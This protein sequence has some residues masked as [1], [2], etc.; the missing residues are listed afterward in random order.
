[1]KRLLFILFGIIAIANSAYA[2]DIIVLYDTTEIEA[3][4]VDVGQTTITYK[5]WSEQNGT[6]LTIERSKI[7]Y[8]KRQDGTKD[9]LMSTPSVTAISGSKS[10]SSPIV[11]K[12]KP[13]QFQGYTHGGLICLYSNEYGL[14]VG[15]IWDVSLGVNLFERFYIGGTLGIY[16]IFASKYIDA[17]TKIKSRELLIPIAPISFKYY[18]T[19]GNVL[20]PFIDFSAGAF[21]LS[22][23]VTDD[24]NSS[25]QS[26]SGALVQIGFG[27]TVKKFSWSIGYTGLANIGI[28][29]TFHI[30]LGACF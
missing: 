13:A 22:S 7:F 6:T 21:I 19:R 28:A 3:K 20:N 1:M 11:R 15:P 5:K 14:S 25:T 26:T 27:Y 8:I 17:Y 18:F 23:Q 24:V 29:N 30:K 9:Y 4:I 10:E 16:T 2:Q 12:Y